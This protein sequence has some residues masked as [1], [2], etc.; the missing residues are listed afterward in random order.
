MKRDLGVIP[1]LF[2]GTELPEDLSCKIFVARDLTTAK[3][4]QKLEE[5][6]KLF[7]DVAL[8]THAP[9]ALIDTWVRRAASGDPDTDLYR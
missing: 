6:R 1:V 4:L 9:L 7:Q 2:S 3:R 8:Q 5:L